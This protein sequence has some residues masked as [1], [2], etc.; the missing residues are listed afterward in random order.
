[1]RPHEA[2]AR[3]IA[4]SYEPELNVHVKNVQKVC[5]RVLRDGGTPA[6]LTR[7]A[8]EMFDSLNERV[9]ERF[10]VSQACKAGCAYCCCVPVRVSALEVELLACE[11]KGK[12]DSKA[13]EA[14]KQRIQTVLAERIKGN[15]P[16]CA[17][18]GPDDRCTVYA[19]RP[20]NCR[21]CNSPDAE[22][23]KAYAID[24]DE[25]PRKAF[26]LPLIIAAYTRFAVNT[27]L[28]IQLPP[29]TYPDS[30]ELME[31]LLKLL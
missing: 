26:A 6:D 30:D 8:N 22:P 7:R 2:E 29:G 14:L 17:L 25:S 5:L 10:E 1:M 3:R 24:G 11:L 9:Y 13:I 23:W 12:L 19:V 18:L 21:A 4:S 27:T 20:M 15:R 28:N 31:S 16:S